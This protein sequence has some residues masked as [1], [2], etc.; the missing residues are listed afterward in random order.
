MEANV[1]TSE[2]PDSALDIDWTARLD[3]ATG[4]PLDK[5]LFTLVK[6]EW[7]ATG[8]GQAEATGHSRPSIEGGWP[9]QGMLRRHTTE[10]VW[11]P[12]TMS[13]KKFWGTGR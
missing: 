10:K 12:G 11:P 1:K 3:T 5:E 2:P 8:H 13:Q 4:Q 7:T 6:H 9:G